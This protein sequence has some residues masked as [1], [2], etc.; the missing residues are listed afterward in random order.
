MII[1]TITRRRFASSLALSSAIAGCSA[2]TSEAETATTA[3]PLISTTSPALLPS[4]VPDLPALPVRGRFAQKNSQGSDLPYLGQISRGDDLLAPPVTSRAAWVAASTPTAL[5]PR[6][7]DGYLSS[8]LSAAD[9]DNTGV[10]AGAVG[11]LFE[12]LSFLGVTPDASHETFTT[13]QGYSPIRSRWQYAQFE[14]GGSFRGQPLLGR[15]VKNPSPPAVDEFRERGARLYCAARKLG[16]EQGSTARSMGEQVAFSVK[17]LGHRID[18]LVVEPLLSLTGPKAFDQGDGPFAPASDGAQAFEVPMGF[19]TKITPIRGIGLPGLREIR[20][21]VELVTADSEGVTSAAFGRRGDTTYG[22]TKQYMTAEHTDA[23]QSAWETMHTGVTVPLF[24][25]GILRVTMTINLDADIGRPLLPGASMPIGVSPQPYD[26][27]LVQSAMLPLAYGATRSSFSPLLDGG[28]VTYHDGAWTP[29]TCHV[30]EIGPRCPTWDWAVVPDQASTLWQAKSAA[31][32]AMGTRLNQ[33]DDHVY[34]T[35]T[36]LGITGKVKGSIGFDRVGPFRLSVDIDGG[37]NGTVGQSHILRDGV[38]AEKLPGEESMRAAAAVT[39]RP[40]TDASATL[41]DTF[42]T[43]HFSMHIPFYGDIHWDPTLLHIDPVTLASWD[44]DTAHAQWHED[45]SLRIGTSSGLGP[46]T[47]KPDVYSHLPQGLDAPSF[48]QSVDE[49]LADSRP[50]P[51][52][53]PLCAS[54]PPSGAPPHANT[55]AYFRGQLP[56]SVCGD[57][58]RAAAYT[59]A[60]GAK[61]ACLTRYFKFLCQPVENQSG[62]TLSHIVD[63]GSERTMSDLGSIMTECIAAYVPAGAPEP[64]TAATAFTNSFFKMGICDDTAALISSSDA[65]GPWDPSKSPSDP[66][67]VTPPRSACR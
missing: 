44:S 65:L 53:P 32:G 17:L 1:K 40:R 11:S 19:G 60:T 43:L 2:Q 18:F 9:A 37:I 63:L 50:N 3:E 67:S 4:S 20:Y 34:R 58:G 59:G 28:R 36:S 10:D 8:A 15:M 56:T 38:I 6:P 61:A 30:T 45:S 26:R 47:K 39:V 66:S 27:V 35:R 55:C 5:V 23:I 21:P 24:E 62:G 12:L 22:A 16:F 29:N 64:T 13:F 57:V 25:A 33:D 31:L 49:C 41:I 52:V 54:E 14:G 42:A 46:A 48:D 7:L 51:A